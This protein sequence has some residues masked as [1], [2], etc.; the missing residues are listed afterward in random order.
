[1]ARGV[2]VNETGIIQAFHITTDQPT[3]AYDLFPYGE[4]GNATAGASLLLPTSVW[5]TNY[6]AVSPTSPSPL[7]QAAPELVLVGLTDDTRFT[8]RPTAAIREG[9]NVAGSAKGVP[10]TY[11][12]SKGQ[13]LV[14]QQE[15]SLTGSPIE[16][17]KP[18][19]VFGMPM[20]LRRHS[21]STSSG[22]C[23]W[24]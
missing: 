17:N 24:P 23:P 8:I 10:A 15:E 3:V 22:A 19:G 7:E 4:S 1:M 11:T 6:V 5:D 16:S 21:L 12:L 20:L 18:I 14:F 13:A 2:G 9:K